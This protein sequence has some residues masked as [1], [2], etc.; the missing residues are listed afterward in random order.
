MQMVSDSREELFSERKSMQE[1]YAGFIAK[2]MEH[3]EDADSD[4]R[5]SPRRIAS[6]ILEPVLQ[7]ETGLHLIG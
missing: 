5:T 6:C 1:V 2:H 7:V 3:Y 4:G